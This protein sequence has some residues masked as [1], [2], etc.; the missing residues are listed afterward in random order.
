MMGNTHWVF[1]FSL[2]PVVVEAIEDMALISLSLS[3]GSLFDTIHK[4]VIYRNKVSTLFD[5]NSVINMGVVKT[6]SHYN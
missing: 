1:R 3:P 5:R 2:I 6:H 4:T